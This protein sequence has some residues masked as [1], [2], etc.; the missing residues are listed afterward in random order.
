MSVYSRYRCPYCGANL[1]PC[2]CT[3]EEV[4]ARA[5][6]QD[7]QEAA[8]RA[9]YYGPRKPVKVVEDTFA[10]LGRKHADPAHLIAWD[11]EEQLRD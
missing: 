2:L 7:A 6:D 3:K 11:L 9:A 1:N 10:S 4:E 5:A 8:E